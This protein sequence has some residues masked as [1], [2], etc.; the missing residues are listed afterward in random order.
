MVVYTDMLMFLF[1]LGSLAGVLMM[2]ITFYGA[3]SVPAKAVTIYI[4]NYGE[5]DIEAFITVPIILICA[6]GSV[7]LGGWKLWKS[8]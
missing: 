8:I 7:I 1:V 6:F 2:S 4:D 3:Y 5:A